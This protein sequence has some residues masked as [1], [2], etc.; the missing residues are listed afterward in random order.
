MSRV[1]PLHPRLEHLR[2]EAKE[3]L[4]AHSRGD[5]AACKT[6]RL[7]RRLRDASGERIL[8]SQI[9]L[10]EAQFTLAMD[11]GFRGWEDLLRHVESLRASP[12]FES[13]ARPGAY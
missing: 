3:L 6:C 1:L 10:T 8:A 11:Y 7:L 5:P 13:Q 12:D 4:R 2:N 9:A